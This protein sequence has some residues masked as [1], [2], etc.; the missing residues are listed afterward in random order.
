MPTTP[1]SHSFRCCCFFLTSELLRNTC[2]LMLASEMLH[3]GTS[4]TLNFTRIH[5]TFSHFLISLATE[6]LSPAILAIPESQHIRLSTWG[7]K[8]LSLKVRLSSDGLLLL[9]VHKRV[10]FCCHL[11]LLKTLDLLAFGRNKVIFIF[12][13]LFL[14]WQYKCYAL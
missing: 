10:G 8:T 9:H 5:Q 4:V 6:L 14:L 12:F 11:C 7:W 13:F 2:S 3:W 1:T